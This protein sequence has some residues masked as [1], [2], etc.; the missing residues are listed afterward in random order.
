ME[1]TQVPEAEAAYPVPLVPLSRT[2]L[3]HHVLLEHSPDQITPP[4]VL[5]AVMVL[6]PMKLAQAVLLARLEPIP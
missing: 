1:V 5:L 2:I 6:S 3:A 4:H